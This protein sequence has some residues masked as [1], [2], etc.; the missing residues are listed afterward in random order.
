M[1][2][3]QPAAGHR[4]VGGLGATWEAEKVDL[5]GGLKRIQIALATL[6]WTGR[7]DNQGQVNSETHGP[8]A[9]GEA[10]TPDFRVVGVEV[11]VK[12]KAQEETTQ[13]E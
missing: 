12:A 5:T 9:Q 3:P 13:E 2:E 4:G 11:V 6:N 10:R 1:Q 7:L 8:G